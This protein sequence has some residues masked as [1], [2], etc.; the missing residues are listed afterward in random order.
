MMQQGGITNIGSI[1]GHFVAQA[2]HDWLGEGGIE[3][4]ILNTH[5]ANLNSMRFLTIQYAHYSHNSNNFLEAV[6]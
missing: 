3:I 5:D 4:E 6:L 1:F 2:T